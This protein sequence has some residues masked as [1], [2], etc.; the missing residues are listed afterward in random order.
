MCYGAAM[1]ESA[2]VPVRQLRN[3]TAEVLRRV[4]AGETLEVTV[5]DRPVAQLVPLG[6]RPRR[7]NTRAFLAQLPLADAGLR[8]EL[9]AAMTATTDDIVDPWQR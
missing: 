1:A 5:N 2:R 7:M 8:D 9:A 3:H 6:R 4:E